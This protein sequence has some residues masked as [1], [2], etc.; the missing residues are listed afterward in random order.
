TL[1]YIIIRTNVIGY[2]FSSRLKITDLMND[3]FVG[4]SGGERLATILYTL[5]VYVKLLVFPH[6]LTHDY[7]PYHIPIM[8]FGKPG[9]L[10]SLAL[11]IGLAF[12]FFKL[13][14]QKNI[15]AWSIAFFVATISI[16]SNLFFPV[17]TFMNERFIFIP[18]IAFS[19][20]SAWVIVRHGFESQKQ[21]AKYLAGAILIILIAGYAFK[22]YDRIPAWKNAL[23]LNGQAAV[24]SENSA[25]ANSFMATALFELGRDTS[26]YAAKKQLFDE[27]EFYAKR[28]IEIYPNYNAANQIYAGLVA[29]RY[30]RDNNQQYL[31]DEFAKILDRRPDTEYVYQFSEYLNRQL[32]PQT[33]ADFY[34]RVAYEIMVTKNQEYP[35]AVQYLKLAET[36]APNDARILFALGTAL[37]RGGDEVQG[38]E[39]LNRSYQLNPALRP[40]G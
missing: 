14:K 7:Y 5:G 15:Y 29:E 39:Y 18:S 23:S 35:R 38:N 21:W 13:W 34:Y 27:A 31:F 16:V 9:T 4:M 26:D 40:Q 8:N 30:Q 19:L 11:Y 28:A 6:P 24:V 22:T 3:P 12:T 25:R 10:I 20:V 37:Y 1:I 32:P 36:I 2:L 17:G 33:M